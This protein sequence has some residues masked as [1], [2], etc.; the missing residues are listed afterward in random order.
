MTG[1]P[2]LNEFAS[3]VLEK[4]CMAL[5]YVKDALEVARQCLTGACDAGRVQAWAGLLDRYSL[6]V[7]CAMIVSAVCI[8]EF[9]VLWADRKSK[10]LN[11]SHLRLSRIPSSA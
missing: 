1:V 9:G 6:S 8:A 3:V 11:S 7:S 2:V 10:R 4:F 5:D